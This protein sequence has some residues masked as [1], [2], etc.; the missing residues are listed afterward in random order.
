VRGLEGKTAIVSGAGSGVG[1]GTAAV[2]ATPTDLGWAVRLLASDEARYITGVGLIVDGG[3]TL[4]EGGV[5]P[6][7]LTAAATN[8]QQRKR[9]PHVF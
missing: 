5:S 9:D 2:L 4:A 1:A 3:Q 6:A 7:V 8:Q